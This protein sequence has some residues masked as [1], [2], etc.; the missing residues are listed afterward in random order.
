MPKNLLSIVVQCSGDHDITAISLSI[1]GRKLD[2]SMQ[3]RI[4]GLW[5]IVKFRRTNHSRKQLEHVPIFHEYCVVAAGK[6]KLTP[7]GGHL[8][9]APTHDAR[10]CSFSND[11]H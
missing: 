1:A 11:I 2:R 9:L 3:P 8:I 10:S 5:Q 4:A 7:E 6:K